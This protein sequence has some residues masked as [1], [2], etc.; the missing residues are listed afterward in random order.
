[1][2]DQDLVELTRRSMQQTNTR[3][4]GDA[5]AWF[6]PD[7]VFDVSEAGVGRFEGREA[8]RSYLEDWI[9]AYERQEY[10]SWEGVALGGGVV[11]VVAEL[12]ALPAG[13]AASVRERWAFTVL[14]REGA[15]ALVTASREIERARE[16]AAALAAAS[17]RVPEASPGEDAVEIVRES[18]RSW[19]RTGEPAWQL[20]HADA[21][22]RDHDIMDGYEYRGREGIER[23]LAD[24]ESA[25]S[26]FSMHAE[27][28]IDA[29]E[30]VVVVFVRM[31][32]TGRGSAA[33]VERDDA[34]V[35]RVRDGLIA[36][37]DYFNDR[38]QALAAAG[39][40]PR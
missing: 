5:V 18:L 24:W 29:G 20:T 31:R 32:A 23:W 21:E 22:V 26:A 17:P 13:S 36:E 27:E 16:A 39:I 15:I 30:G 33:S 35:Y 37:L 2:P 19:R 8:I 6:A 7:A 14:W 10:R 9:G 28:F 38:A 25:W 1:M 12:E 4:F 34:I 11:F 40:A 3:D